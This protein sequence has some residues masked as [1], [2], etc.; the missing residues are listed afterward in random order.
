VL[1]LLLLLLP[2]EAPGVEEGEGLEE[3]HTDWTKTITS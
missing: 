3:G 2:P 1:L